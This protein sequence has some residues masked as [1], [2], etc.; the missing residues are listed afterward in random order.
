[1]SLIEGSQCK[2]FCTSVYGHGGIYGNDGT[3][4]AKKHT[5]IWQCENGPRGTYTDTEGNS[6]TWRDFNACKIYNDII[7]K[8][9]SLVVGNTGKSQIFQNVIN[10][11]DK[12][13]P[14]LQSCN[15]EGFV[16]FPQTIYSQMNQPGNGYRKI[17]HES[18]YP[19]V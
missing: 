12:N 19:F 18:L 6:Q 16:N 17:H 9:N 11:L 5:C 7:E 14:K 2:H 15:S 10:N 8:Q 1:M 13:Y 3:E 4:S